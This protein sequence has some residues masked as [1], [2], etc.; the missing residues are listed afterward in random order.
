MAGGRLLDIFFDLTY[1]KI[2]INFNGIK[3]QFQAETVFVK[4]PKQF[5][6]IFKSAG[7]QQ[8]I[9]AIYLR[10]EMDKFYLPGY[11]ILLQESTDINA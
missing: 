2:V 8:N 1:I 3:R 9:G 4:Y 6:R 5:D 11:P 10:S 7:K